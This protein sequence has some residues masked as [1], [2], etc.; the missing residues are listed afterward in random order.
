M[1]KRLLVLAGSKQTKK[2][3]EPRQVRLDGEPKC[4]ACLVQKWMPGF[5]G[6][7]F[8]TIFAEPFHPSSPATIFVL[9]TSCVTTSAPPGRFM[10]AAIYG[11]MS[12]NTL[13]SSNVNW[14]ESANAT[15]SV[16]I[17]FCSDADR[18]MID[19]RPNKGVGKTRS[20]G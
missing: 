18:R 10:D 4:H 8:S 19:R 9:A 2:L 15:P 6:S 1:L 13:S 11:V 7:A 17:R 16:A 5:R 20:Q 14:R 12:R 3:P